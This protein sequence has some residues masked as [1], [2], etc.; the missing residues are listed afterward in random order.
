V[1][2]FFHYGGPMWLIE[3]AGLESA[4]QLEDP[5]S[6]EKIA[7]ALLLEPDEWRT[8][9]YLH[10]ESHGPFRRRL[11]FGQEIAAD[12][13][14]YSRQ[15]FCPA[16]LRQR[17]FWWGIWD[18][19]LVSVCP[20]HACRLVSRC[21]ACGG[22]LCWNR[23]VLHQ[24]RCGQDLRLTDSVHVEDDSVALSAAIY[25]A[26]RMP[27][28][29]GKAVLNSACL[30][31]ELERVGLDALLGLILFFGT[32][33]ETRSSKQSAFRTTDCDA[34]FQI[35]Q[36][37][38]RFL[39]RWPDGFRLQLEKIVASHANLLPVLRFTDVFGGHYQGLLRILGDPQFAFIKT[40][41]ERFVIDGWNGIVRGQ[42]RVVSREVSDRMQWITAQ[43]G[44]SLSGLSARRIADLVR[45]GEIEGTFIQP[46][47]AS[48]RTECWLKRTALDVWRI[49]REDELSKYISSKEAEAS[50]GLTRRTTLSL[51]EVGLIRRV[52]G[53]DK[54]FP[55][56][57]HYLRMDVSNVQAAF[58][59]SLTTDEYSG[60][61]KG[62]KRKLISL[63]EALQRYLGREFGLP[64]VV[65]SVMDGTL[66][67]VSYSPTIPGILGYNFESDQLAPYRHPRPTRTLPKGFIGYDE[68]STILAM[69]TE[70]VRNLAGQKIIRYIRCGGRV[71]VSR[72]DVEQFA[73]DYVSVKALADRFNTTSRW[74]ARY[75]SARG[76][77]LLS[78]DLPGKGR[79]LF[80]SARAATVEI[81]RAKRARP[82]KSPARS[83]NAR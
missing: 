1:A 75:L 50:L 56:G 12:R 72:L 61:E 48:K 35:G 19:G 44:S 69:T 67:P 57:I 10:A 41:F 78:V 8:M 52:E 82:V 23:P 42:H 28:D 79:K 43:Q 16:C 11:F 39:C 81:P 58:R 47:N 70:V 27:H 15:R 73:H 6:V 9:A 68:A 40:E 66:R 32:L 37:A 60:G 76:I 29:S 59:A 62:E 80:V 17:S 36:A 18:I 54:G 34:A 24:C 71:L 31:P 2:T 63:R 38:G 30:A 4:A 33:G 64:K 3:L 53:Q 51:S 5:D 55:V 7:S 20:I 83:V 21:P 26:A 25:R 45:T 13:L 46:H 77:K 74:V 14:N 49:N 65:R 22:D